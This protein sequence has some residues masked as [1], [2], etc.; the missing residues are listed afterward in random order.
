MG[1]FDGIL[2]CSDLDDTLLTSEREI[3]DVNKKAI[4]YFMSEGGKFTFC[5]GR[6]PSGAKLALQYIVPNVP[7]ICFNGAAIYDFNNDRILW[8]KF[9][10]KRAG[11]VIDF[12][13]S[14]MPQIGVEISTNDSVYHH[15]SNR[16]TAEHVGIEKILHTNL[17]YKEIKEDW[18]KVIFMAELSDM[19][20]LRN[21]IEESEFS[22]RYTFIQ[23]YKH[24]YELLPK[25]T[26]KGEAMLELAK[27]LSIDRKK[28]VGVGDNE[29][30]ISLVRLAGVG[31]AVLN[32]IEEVKN[33]A[34]YITVDNDSNA[35]ADIINAIE[36]RKIIF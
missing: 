12:V 33:V 9:L 27:I 1:K 30:D 35:L 5:T 24:Y 32:A 17:D 22:E 15:R 14:N 7:M 11:E 29:N 28:T 3:S 19:P 21:L 36:N 16:L 4:E 25:G 6:V 26:G 31:V 18:K 2:I 34:H 23:S 20:K 10:D 13:L 8:E